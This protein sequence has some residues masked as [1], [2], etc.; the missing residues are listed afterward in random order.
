VAG[1]ASG[2]ALD[3]VELFNPNTGTS[4]VITAKLDQPRAVH[5]GDGNHVCAGMTSVGTDG[6]NISSCY[7][8]AT[9]D[10]INLL[11]GSYKH[12][13]WS[14]DTGIYLLG[15]WDGS[16]YKTTELV[17]GDTTQAMFGLK[18]S[19]YRACGIPDG[20]SYIM[21]GGAATQTTVSRYSQTGWMEDLPSLNT[22]RY[23]HGCGTYVDSS[24]QQI[25]LVTGGS[26]NSFT[27][28]SSTEQL[29]KNGESWTIKENSLPARMRGLGT[30]SFNNQIITTGGYD[31]DSSVFSD[32]IMVW[33][34]ETATFKEIGKL[35]QRRYYHSVSVVDIN[36]FTCS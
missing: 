16:G 20:D 24:N 30:I 15:G 35:E 12:T 33:D 11:N 29:V 17:T 6:D 36:D 18:Y 14:T 7:N 32:K 3:L 4:C 34:Q 25:Y 26:S 21:T 10:T 31:Q 5:T 27:Y 9:G 13:S 8:V 28:H 2:S 1:G 23:Y 19:T 22:E